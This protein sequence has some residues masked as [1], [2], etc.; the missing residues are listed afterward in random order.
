MDR[1]FY[2]V[3]VVATTTIA[4]ASNKTTGKNSITRS[5]FTPF[6]KFETR[7]RPGLFDI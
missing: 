1:A 6:Q 5:R 3:V 7:L 2:D 4:E